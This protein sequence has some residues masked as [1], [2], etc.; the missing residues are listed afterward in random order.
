M[1][2]KVKFN[3][4][5]KKKVFA[6]MFLCT[7]LGYT[8]RETYTQTKRNVPAKNEIFFFNGSELMFKNTLV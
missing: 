7:I 4:T 8:L 5:Q 1:L 6:Q 3:L 2:Y